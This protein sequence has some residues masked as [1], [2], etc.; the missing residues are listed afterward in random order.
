MRRFQRANAQQW[1]PR[2]DITSL[3]LT[4]KSQGNEDVY[5]YSHFFY[6]RGGGTFLEM[7]A[8]NGVFLSTTYSLDKDL[9]WRGVH[10]EASPSN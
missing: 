9:G 3:E 7:G 5:A 10:V 6:G 1:T 2:P 8:L 4:T